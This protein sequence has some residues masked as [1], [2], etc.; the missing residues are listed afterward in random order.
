VLQSSKLETDYLFPPLYHIQA[1]QM[2]TEGI[3]FYTQMLIKYKK[4]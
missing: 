2:P 3:F 4:E 1:I